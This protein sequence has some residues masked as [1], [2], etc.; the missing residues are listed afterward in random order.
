MVA[1]AEEV[2]VPE[3]AVHADNSNGTQSS[4]DNGKC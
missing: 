1:V 3:D 2:C 4:P